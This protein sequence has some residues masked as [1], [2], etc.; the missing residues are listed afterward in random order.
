MGYHTVP[1]AIAKSVFKKQD[2]NAGVTEYTEIDG[3]GHSLT[4][5]NG[6]QDVADAVLEFVRR[7]VPARPNPAHHKAATL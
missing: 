2:E 1:P 3:R 7:F 4:I 6:W 5:D